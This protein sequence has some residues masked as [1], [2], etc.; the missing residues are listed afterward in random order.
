M[1]VA[2]LAFTCANL[3][4]VI[5]VELS[6]ETGKVAVFKVARKDMLCEFLGLTR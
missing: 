4:K 6:H 3:V 2:L 5:L 1:S